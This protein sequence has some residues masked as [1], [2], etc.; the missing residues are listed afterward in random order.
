MA[1]PYS[2]PTDS[3]LH[4]VDV[5]WTPTAFGVAITAVL[6]A[7]AAYIPI[8]GLRGACFCLFPGIS[9]RSLRIGFFGAL[10]GFFSDI[11]VS[12][13]WMIIAG[14]WEPRWGGYNSILIHYLPPDIM[15]ATHVGSPMPNSMKFGLGLMLWSATMH[16]TWM[17]IWKPRLEWDRRLPII[18]AGSIIICVGATVLWEVAPLT[19]TLGGEYQPFGDLPLVPF[20]AIFV[21]TM[22][23]CSLVVALLIY[24]HSF[25]T[26]K[27]LD[28]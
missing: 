26:P 5:K 23:V 7:F 18:G 10:V 17:S 13:V 1:N 11:A 6:A 9:L 28:Q 15:V 4:R 12:I 14:A 8:V 27:A 20:V 21:S 24:R 2:P 19:G 25:I 16:L 3:T 22:P